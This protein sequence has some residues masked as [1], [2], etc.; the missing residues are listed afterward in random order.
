MFVI[1]CQ[2][3]VFQRG[4]RYQFSSHSLCQC[5]RAVVYSEHRISPK[6]GRSNKQF[7]F[8]ILREEIHETFGVFVGCMILNTFVR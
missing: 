5:W 2:T 7:L 8:W 3:N 4:L 6:C 1:P